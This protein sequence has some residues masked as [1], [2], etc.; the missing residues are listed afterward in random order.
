MTEGTDSAVM[1]TDERWAPVTHVNLSEEIADRLIANI[2]NGSF[3]FG[4]K[5]PAEREL[6]KYLNVGRPT[7]REALRALS[8]IGLVE[9]RPGEGAYVVNDHPRFVAKAF[10]WA[11]LL[12]APTARE[13]I[14]ARVAIETELA[15]LAAERASEEEL[16]RV[17][18]HV[19]GMEVSGGD[20]QASADEDLGFHLAI[21]A[22][23]ENQTLARILSAIQSLMKQWILRALITG[24]AGEAAL[25]D[26]RRILNALEKRDVEAARSAMRTHL[27]SMG[28]LFLTIVLDEDM[29]VR[30]LSQTTQSA[31]D[32]S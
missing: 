12:D 19:R 16:E 4:E 28:R 31:G 1:S 6:A 10:S 3:Q 14:E 17:R 5:L 30:A 15:G 24:G 11:V 7:V 25:D 21:A 27:E 2:L 20:A 13:V 26:H 9:V 23:A 8:V 18:A 29:P 22:A 32:G